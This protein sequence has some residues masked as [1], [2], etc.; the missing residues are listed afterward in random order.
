M[1]TTRCNIKPL[2]HARTFHNVILDI[3]YNFQ[4]NQQLPPYAALIIFLIEAQSVL[5]EVTTK[6]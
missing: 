5:Y 4:T 2:K 1:G 3:L 6:F